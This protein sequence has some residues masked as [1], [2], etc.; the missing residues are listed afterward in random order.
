MY[1]VCYVMIEPSS[2]MKG[3]YISLSVFCGGV[4]IFFYGIY[5]E[6]RYCIIE[7]LELHCTS[8]LI[9]IANVL[10]TQCFLWESWCCKTFEVFFI[11]VALDPL[12]LNQ[13]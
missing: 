9:D 7:Y 12:S 5:E 13:C 1:C 10:S 4:R 8:I 11:I 3:P 2:V 6:L